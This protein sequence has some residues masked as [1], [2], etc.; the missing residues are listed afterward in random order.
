LNPR[1]IA[2]EQSDHLGDAIACFPMAALLKRRFPAARMVFVGKP[3]V[4]ALVDACV[5]IDEFLELDAVLAD[6]TQLSVRN[7]DVCLTPF[8]RH[9][10]GEAARRAGVR[11][12]IG[13]L[14][15]PK[16]LRWANRFISQGNQGNPR[17]IANMF[18]RYLRP[19]GIR[20]ELPDAELGTLAGLERLPPLDA[21]LQ[22]QLDPVRFNLIIH[23]KSNKSGREWPAAHFNQLAGL[24]PPDRF[25]LLLTGS[26]AERALLQID[27]PQLLE[28]AGGGDLMGHTSLGQLLALIGRADGMVA[29]STGPLHVAAALGRHALGLYPGRYS[30]NTVRWRPLGPRAESIS[31][32]TECRQAEGRCPDRYNG[33]PC[34]C[35]AG[36][37]PRLVADRILGWRA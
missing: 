11:I 20:A 2:I 35:M 1:A 23:P 18:L 12:R 30:H 17:H 33:E 36:I 26:T 31:F 8:L 14:H 16:S 3:Y 21:G 28:R 29:N 24:L 7:V 13:N 27:C 15:R 6:P 4:R 9:A 19:L 10:F 34:S 5:H 25:K 22:Q 32:R 37:A